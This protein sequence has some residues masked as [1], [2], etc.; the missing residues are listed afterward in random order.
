[1]QLLEPFKGNDVKHIMFK[2][3]HNK[4]PDHDGYGSVF[5]KHDWSIVGS[6]ITE[7]VL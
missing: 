5:F 7:V 6:D 3:D 1:M 2:I 4:N